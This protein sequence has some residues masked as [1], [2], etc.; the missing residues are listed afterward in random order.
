VKDKG[1]SLASAP[2][3]RPEAQRSRTVAR[4]RAAAAAGDGL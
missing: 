1:A 3:V 2:V 4:P